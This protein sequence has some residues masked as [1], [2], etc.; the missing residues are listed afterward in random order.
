[1]RTA[2]SQPRGN[3]NSSSAKTYRR[4]R[5]RSILEC[6]LPRTRGTSCSD[7][8]GKLPR[9]RVARCVTSAA[10]PLCSIVRSP[11]STVLPAARRPHGCRPSPT[12]PSGNGSPLILLRPRSDALQSGGWGKKGGPPPI[13]TPTN[14]GPPGR[15]PE[16][17]PPPPPP[18]PPSPPPPPP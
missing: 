18:P 5:L 11:A 7:S 2:F 16:P 10:R 13:L 3:R 1:M 17:P 9:T 8:I 15:R 12:H 6:G 14:P 4:S